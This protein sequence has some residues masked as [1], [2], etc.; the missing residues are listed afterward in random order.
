M[1]AWTFC[2]YFYNFCIWRWRTHCLSSTSTVRPHIGFVSEILVMVEWFQR[3]K[4]GWLL[5]ALLDF[6]LWTIAMIAHGPSF[7][8]RNGIILKFKDQLKFLHCQFRISE[9]LKMESCPNWRVYLNRNLVHDN[10]SSIYICSNQS[11]LS[12]LVKRTSI[13]IC[14]FYEVGNISIEIR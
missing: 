14:L 11:F 7:S 3:P 4:S 10:T 12:V 8:L 5:W 9:F 1:S 13:I 6:F 2:I